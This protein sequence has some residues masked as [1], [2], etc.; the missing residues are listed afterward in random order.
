MIYFALGILAPYALLLTS[1][2]L[3]RGDQFTKQKE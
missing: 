3:V 2:V 1:I